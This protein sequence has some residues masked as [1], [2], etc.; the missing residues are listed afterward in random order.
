[1]QR[2]FALCISILAAW[3]AAGGV[4]RADLIVNQSSPASWEFAFVQNIATDAGAGISIT[5]GTAPESPISPPE[6]LQLAD[7]GPIGPFPITDPI[8][9]I[10]STVVPNDDAVQ[11]DESPAED[12]GIGPIVYSGSVTFVEKTEMDVPTLGICTCEFVSMNFDSWTVVF[13]EA[14]GSGAA[15]PSAEPLSTDAPEP[16][17][18]MLIVL[19]TLTFPSNAFW[20]A[21]RAR[22]PFIA[23]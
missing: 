23:S 19:A 22:S 7:Y 20:R 6:L 14:A 3:S 4:C 18:A 2:T 12:H 16:T 15:L 10:T 1:M 13:A 11:F 9:V 8:R 17:T 21:R 5:F